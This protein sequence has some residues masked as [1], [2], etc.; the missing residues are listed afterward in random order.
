MA[1]VAM[2]PDN[3]RQGRH[4]KIQYG[5]RKPEVVIFPLL[6]K[7]FLK[8]QRLGIFF[9]HGHSNGHVRYIVRQRP[10]PENPIWRPK[11][12]SFRIFR[13]HIGF[14]WCRALLY[15]IAD[16]FAGMAAHVNIIIP[17]GIAQI[18]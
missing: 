16:V 2:P 6:I 14:F 3:A 11:T 9:A 8:F 4:T 18:S 7:I 13:R 15:G 10:T 1:A 5:G 12:D 17:F